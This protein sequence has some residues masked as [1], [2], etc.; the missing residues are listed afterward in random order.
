MEYISKPTRNNRSWHS[1][2]N[3]K[4]MLLAIVATCPPVTTEDLIIISDYKPALLREVQSLPEKSKPPSQSP[5]S[6]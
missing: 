2:W 6:Y 1:S 3:Y 4:N 5:V